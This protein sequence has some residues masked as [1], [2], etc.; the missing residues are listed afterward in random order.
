MK[1]FN[2]HLVDMFEAV[3][4]LVFNALWSN[5]T[6]NSLIARESISMWN[7]LVR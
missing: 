2:E 7:E 1:Q 5:R 6:K 3:Y 4:K